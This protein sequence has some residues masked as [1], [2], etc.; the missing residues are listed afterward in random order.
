MLNEIRRIGRVTTRVLRLMAKGHVLGLCGT[1]ALMV[2]VG[3]LANVPAMVV[4]SLVDTIQ[5]HG[6]NDGQDTIML[7]LGAVFGAFFIRELLQIGRK[8]VVE[9]ACT[10]SE[11]AVR[12]AAVRH[13]LQ[14][15]LAYFRSQMTG[16][17]HGRL[18][19]SIEG[20]VRL[21][22]LLFLDF[23][24]TAFVALSA[25]AI[26]LHRHALIGAVM[27]AVVPVGLALVIAQVGSQKGIRLS[28]LRGKEEIDGTVV[29]LLGNIES[30]RA[31][32]A[33]EFEADRVE[34]VSERLR[35]VEMRHHVLM[36]FFDAGKQL[37]EGLFHVVVLG[38]S[39]YCVTTG[40]IT[41]G[42]VVTFSMLFAGVVA[43]LREIHRIIDEAHES[44]L[45]VDDL[46]D[47]LDQPHDAAFLVSPSLVLPPRCSVHKA[48]PRDGDSGRA[49][50]T[51]AMVIRQLFF[52]YP[53]EPVD[54][55]K[56]V[57]LRVARGEFVGLCGPAGCGKS[58]LLKA[59]LRLV[60]PA[61]GA[62]DLWDRPIELWSRSELADA[63]GYVG[64]RPFLVSGTVRDNIAYG[65]KK[66]LDM[67]AIVEAAK[68]ANIH[69]EIESLPAGYEYQVGERGEALSG[70]QRQRVA[71][72]R[73]FLRSPALLLLDEATS[74]L[75]N[76]NERAV[77]AAIERAMDGRTVIA[78]AHR[79]STLRNADRVL[80]MDGGRIV[81]A[82]SY[83]DLA[84][85]T[86][87]FSRLV[88]AGEDRPKP[89][90]AVL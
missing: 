51:D 9:N 90:A 20:L 63:I 73:V 5:E 28:L 46:F 26:A 10:R 15:D 7:A 21:V 34:Q 77:Q 88:S 37:N 78:V 8:L 25:L 62:I 53:G 82:G 2:G 55:I 58:T 84:G 36:A 32:D 22:K 17:L 83:F 12:V 71:L 85:G 57:S 6:A 42:D 44:S 87:L 61:I 29:E 69:Q 67:D 74:A 39:I 16:A 13:L 31:I 54:V 81:E 70:G 38:L 79:L 64:Q 1:L 80:V 56:G 18:S 45:R 48:P 3:L 30:V 72:A 76:L 14:L 86:G 66:D 68:L 40:E 52:R 27:A 35:R 47:I 89:F 60:H 23:G 59:I 50:G 49:P 75:D 11:K 24:P 33:I 65:I 41:A 43:P 19:R 4:G